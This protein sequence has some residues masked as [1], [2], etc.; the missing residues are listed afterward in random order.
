MRRA[1]PAPLHAGRE[2][3]STR[4]QRCLRLRPK[5]QPGGKHAQTSDVRKRRRDHGARVRDERRR[6]GREPLPDQLD[7]T[8]TARKCSRSSGARPAKPAETGVTGATGA[9][10]ASGKEAHPGACRPARD[11]AAEPSDAARQLR[12]TPVREGRQRNAD[13]DLLRLRP[14]GGARGALTSSSARRLPQ[15]AP[16]P[17][18]HRRPPPAISASTKA[19]TAINAASMRVFD[20]IGGENGLA[21]KYGAGVAAKAVAE[22]EYRV[23]GS[24]AVTAP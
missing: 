18:K 1:R 14:L 16:A 24:W 19:K 21:N 6:A 23:R 22:G 11:D 4:P 5:L 7:Q 13:P 12:R 10:G 9:T 17:P 20:P 8:D 3:P 2:R 15:N